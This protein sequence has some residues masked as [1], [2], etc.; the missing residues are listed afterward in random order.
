MTTDPSETEGCAGFA[1]LIES[2]A[3][4]VIPTDAERAA[5]AARKPVAEAAPSGAAGEAKPAT[6]E[7]VNA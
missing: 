3:E 7:K 4:G 1:H 6:E 2:E 5:L